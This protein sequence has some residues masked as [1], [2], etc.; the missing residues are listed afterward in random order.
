M[1]AVRTKKEKEREVKTGRK[2]RGEEEGKEEEHVFW[3]LREVNSCRW[4][5]AATSETRWHF[6]AVTLPRQGTGTR[7]HRPVVAMLTQQDSR[8]LQRDSGES[9]DLS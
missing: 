8:S 7:R 9:D 1:K 4:G 5:S 2:R 3:I 6:E